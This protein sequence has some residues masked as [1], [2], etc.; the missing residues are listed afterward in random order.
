M[1]IIMQLRKCRVLHAVVTRVP[2]WQIGVTH[3]RVS[4]DSAVIELVIHPHL[5]AAGSLIIPPAL[6]R[7]LKAA[8]CGC[9]CPL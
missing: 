6:P 2:L 3:R 4:A 9:E 1:S 5:A 8:K 7:D